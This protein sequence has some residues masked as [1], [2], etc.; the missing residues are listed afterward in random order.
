MLSGLSL[1][2]LTGDT[3]AGSS[4]IVTLPKIYNGINPT[5]AS[6]SSSQSPL[7]VGTVF[8]QCS[9]TVIK[10]MVAASFAVTTMFTWKGWS[11]LLKSQSGENLF[12]SDRNPL[13]KIQDSFFNTFKPLFHLPF[14]F[15]SSCVFVLCIMHCI[16][17]IWTL[18][19]IFHPIHSC[20]GIYRVS[21]LYNSART[22]LIT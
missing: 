5:S 10:S 15:G 4:P 9:K 13:E 2:S 14:C 12:C 22:L 8:G 20:I 11:A 19:P 6:H 16:V 3:S 18:P 1:T 21:F 17:T 7:L